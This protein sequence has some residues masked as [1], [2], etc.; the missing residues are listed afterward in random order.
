[1][2]K[3]FTLVEVLVA[4]AILVSGV[5]AVFQI[6]GEGFDHLLR[7]HRYQNLYIAMSNIPEELDR[8]H[9]FEPGVAQAGRSGDF[10]Y[11][12]TATVVEPPQPILGFDEL[13]PTHHSL[14]YQIVLKVYFSGRGN[15][16]RF[17]EIV[18]YK[19]GWARVQR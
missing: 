14:L 16:R 15:E 18:F 8:R 5:V 19:S 4:L 12:W 17:R 6:F 11:E 13:P 7:F 2:R 9:D 3:G 1:M 10:D